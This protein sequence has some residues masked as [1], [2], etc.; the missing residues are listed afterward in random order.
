MNMKTWKVYGTVPIS[1]T[2][3]VEAETAEEAIEAAYDEFD[4]LTQYAGNG[5]FGKLVGTSSPNVSLEALDDGTVFTEA[6]EA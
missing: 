2:V 4:G 1:V 3:T 6:N 5:G